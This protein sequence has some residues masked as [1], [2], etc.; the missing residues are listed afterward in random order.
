MAKSRG[1]ADSGARAVCSKKSYLDAPLSLLLL[2]LLLLLQ[3][4]LKPVQ[5]DRANI[6]RDDSEYKWMHC[7]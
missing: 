6:A 3:P 4:Q 2:V 1:G 5:S 7:C